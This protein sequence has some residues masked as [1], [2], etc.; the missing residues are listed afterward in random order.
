MEI[1][2]YL[3][4]GFLESGK[5]AFVKETLSDP[6]FNGSEK[7]L[8][9]VFEE[10]IEEYEEDFLSDNRVTK[11]EVEEPEELTE[12]F[13]ND[14]HKKYKPDRVMIEYNGVWKLETLFN[15]AL[16][17]EWALVQI[18]TTVDA[19]TFEVHMSNMRSM[20]VEQLSNSDLI[21]FNRCNANTKKN[22]LRRS[23]KVVNRKA[24][25]MYESEDGNLDDLEEDDMPFDMNASVIKIEDD[26]YGL[27]YMDALDNP[28]KYNRRIVQFKG[29]VYKGEKFPKDC[30][31]PGRFAVTCC[32]DDMQFVGFICMGKEAKRLNQKDWIKLTAEVRSEYHP[33]YDKEGPVLYVKK[34]EYT[35]PP[36]EPLVYFN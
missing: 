32:A 1:P 30:F 18:I 3:V 36:I 9:I 22:A 19:S 34:I 25:I 24:Q 23:I 15:A 31:V 29:M 28:T 11:V 10:G 8:L 5:T 20:L 2:V 21:I 35:E 12:E 33:G 27:W 7:T 13:L 16:P 14:C 6:E 4:T 26:D 17:K